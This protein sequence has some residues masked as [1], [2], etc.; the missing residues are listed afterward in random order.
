ML[1][2]KLAER[3]QGPVD[4]GV[5]EAARQR[6]FDTLSCYVDGRGTAEG[7]LLERLF[8]NGAIED[9]IRAMAGAIRSTELDDIHLPSCTTIGSFVVPA[10]VL[11]AVERGCPDEAVLHGLVAGYEAMARLGRAVDGAHIIYQGTWPTYLCAPLAAAAAVARAWD[12][13][14]E[15]TVHAMAIAASRSTGMNARST[16][17]ASSRWYMAGCA[18]AEGCTSARAAEAGLQGDL[19]VLEGAFPR[20]TG[21]QVSPEVLLEDGRGWSILDVDVKPFRSSRQALA[22]TQAFLDLEPGREVASLRVWVPGQV[23]AMVDN[24]AFPLGVQCQLAMAAGDPRSLWDVAHPRPPDAAFAAR[25]QVEED[26]RL[27]ERYPRQ[28][29]GRVEVAWAGGGSAAR[30]VLGIAAPDWAGLLRKHQAVCQ[31]SGLAGTWIEPLFELCQ[32]FGTGQ[33]SAVVRLVRTAAG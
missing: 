27:T 15:H 19:N 29:G 24:P 17:H 21:T 33:L 6:L 4:A 31:A 28:W 9:R 1:L 20:A 3:L 2:E 7:Q 26:R 23:Q 10:A 11:A 13:S 25:V 22:A 32:A 16:G 30:E 8:A 14:R 12:L 5:L 18:A